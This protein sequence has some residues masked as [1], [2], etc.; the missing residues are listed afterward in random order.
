MKIVRIEDI[1][2]RLL[3][4]DPDGFLSSDKRSKPLVV[5]VVTAA[6][7]ASLRR[8]PLDQLQPHTC[9][10]VRGVLYDL[11]GYV[12]GALHKIEAIAQ[13]GQK[14][15][16]IASTPSFPLPSIITMPA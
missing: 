15:R 5:F 4:S 2:K 13:S 8:K 16:G 9:D 1:P 14:S 3:A 11:S 10:P 6:Q 12:A 7:E